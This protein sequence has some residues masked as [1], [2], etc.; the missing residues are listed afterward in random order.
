MNTT[1][2]LGRPATGLEPVSSFTVSLKPSDKL[3]MVEQYGSLTEAIRLLTKGGKYEL[4]VERN[5]ELEN[6]LKNLNK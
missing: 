6:T 2:K 3:H 5:T 4:L 1:P